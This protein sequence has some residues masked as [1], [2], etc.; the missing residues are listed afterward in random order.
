MAGWLFALIA[1]VVFATLGIAE[2]FWF[3]D[4]WLKFLTS[5]T[6]SVLLWLGLSLCLLF[7]TILSRVFY[8]LTRSVWVV[9][10]GLLACLMALFIVRSLLAYIQFEQHT[11]QTRHIV[12]A[13][14]YIDSISDNVYDELLGTSFRQ[15]ATLSDIKPVNQVNLGSG[16]EVYNPF[17]VTKPSRQQ[18]N[19]NGYASDDDQDNSQSIVQLEGMTVL[20]SANPNFAKTDLSAL[21]QVEPGTKLHLDLLITPIDQTVLASGFDANQWLRTRQI[22]AQAQIL[23][24]GQIMPWTVDSWYDKFLI[25]L[26]K[27]RHCL[28]LHFY[29]NRHR[30]D[31]HKAQ[32]MSVTLS[33]LSGDRAL[34]DYNTKQLY[35]LAGISH[36]LAISGSHV[37]FL[38]VIVSAFVLSVMDRFAISIYGHIPKRQIQMLLMVVVSLIYAL[39][40][41]FDV[42]AVRT[43]YMLMAA[44]LIRSLVLPISMTQAVSLVALMMTWLDPY[45]LWQAGFW[46]SFVAVIL[47]MQYQSTNTNRADFGKIAGF[48]WRF[49]QMARLQFWLFVMMLPISVML[50]TK[51]SLWG[52]AVNL[53][54]IGLFGLIIVPLNLLAGSLFVILPEVA[55][56]LWSFSSWLLYDFH[57]LLMLGLDNKIGAIS[58]WLYAPFGMAGF[59]LSFIVVVLVLLPRVMPKR[60]LILPILAIVFLSTS[61]Q[62]PSLLL[63]NLPSDTPNVSQLLLV[64]KEADEVYY[65][66][67][68]NDLGVKS[69]RKGYATLLVDQLQQQGIAR[70]GLDGVIVQSS[71]DVFMPV[72]AVLAQQLP[73]YH[74]WQA[75]RHNPLPIIHHKKC[76]AGMTWHSQHLS[77]R[78]L[79]GWQEIDDER[80]HHC[81]LEIVSDHQLRMQGFELNESSLQTN[82]EL[83]S[84]NDL[85]HTFLIDEDMQQAQASTKT[86]LVIST[87]QDPILWQLWEGICK[88]DDSFQLSQLPNHQ[89]VWLSSMHAK[90]SQS[91]KIQLQPVQTLLMDN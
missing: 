19:R 66:L 82:L 56:I 42:P 7:M 20:L 73:V 16:L 68:L 83:S 64:Q 86:Q 14:A 87:S 27:F 40:T 8:R 15:V 90:G 57:Q 55:D 5:Y 31:A 63:I 61:S 6:F 74:Y 91:A 77:I 25:N 22:H 62:S 18:I 45:V 78:A 30:L 28:R 80:V 39:F 53:I 52:L 69:L 4:D 70:K 43:V 17:S 35:Q 71:S 11:P 46:L 48:M 85:N 88:A 29:Q 59:V 67:I 34:I 37:L 89:A 38:S 13:T 41:G 26:E 58:A 9:K 33:L 23:A 79:T 76:V 54:A 1:I 49:W 60:I 21:K 12:S 75:G 84:Q 3:A 44:W 51:V 36:L 32:A 65:W 24:V 81:E 47:L 72:V 10:I 2:Q 50:F